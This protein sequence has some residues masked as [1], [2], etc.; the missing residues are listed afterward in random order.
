MKEFIAAEAHLKLDAHDD[1]AAGHI[2]Q[3]LAAI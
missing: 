3:I 1:A 2:D